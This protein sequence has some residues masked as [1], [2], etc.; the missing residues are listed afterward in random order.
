MSSNISSNHPAH[1]AM[2]GLVYHH[3]KLH[4]QIDE[5]HREVVQDTY[6]KLKSA[7]IEKK[8]VENIEEIMGK[9]VNHL[10]DGVRGLKQEDIQNLQSSIQ[11]SI[12]TFLEENK[13]NGNSEASLQQASH[14]IQQ[15]IQKMSPVEHTGKL[16]STMGKIAMVAGI[17]G[18]SIGM[19]K[20]GNAPSSVV[21]TNTNT[22]TATSPRM[23]NRE[24][25][26]SLESDTSKTKE[27]I[28]PTKTL[29]KQIAEQ[30]YKVETLSE[31]EQQLLTKIL[32]NH[33]K[34][35]ENA[36]GDISKL[37]KMDDNDLVEAAIAGYRI[38]KQ[39]PFEIS[40]EEAID[41]YNLNPAQ[42]DIFKLLVQH[43]PMNQSRRK[44]TLREIK[45]IPLAL[46][47]KTLNFLKITPLEDL[48]NGQIQV[49]NSDFSD[50][51]KKVDKKKKEM[52]GNPSDAQLK[53]LSDAQKIAGYDARNDAESNA[54]SYLAQVNENNKVS[55][56][57]RKAIGTKVII[58]E[59]ITQ[60]PDLKTVEILSPIDMKLNNY[61]FVDN[62]YKIPDET[63]AEWKKS[64]EKSIN[65]I[66]IEN[67]TKIELS[68]TGS[69]SPVPNGFS[70]DGN[71]YSHADLAE[72]R[73]KEGAKNFINLLP[74]E[75]QKKVIVNYTI[76]PTEDPFNGTVKWKDIPKQDR[77]GV[78]RQ[79]RRVTL[80]VKMNGSKI[81]EKNTPQDAEVNKTII[82]SEVFLY[83][84]QKTE[85][86]KEKEA[87]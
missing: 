47:E 4:E 65:T 9:F 67:I 19:A 42:V 82:A 45:E 72:L 8:E 53:A 29:P 25:M 17:V 74:P 79:S 2:Q 69:C 64:I 41:M 58:E 33:K 13:I 86:E 31:R 37:T 77:P 35:P 44:M 16:Q 48:K 32:E 71:Q 11:Q 18:A 63:I 51:H 62:D 1:K 20:A 55:G 27:K 68:S 3:E 10:Y 50:I 66:G 12:R 46:Q 54:N 81:I 38:A 14:D 28:T 40:L 87:N 70:P 83:T 76:I 34:S 22:E 85:K 23:E 15:L 26:V 75:L 52:G 84:P 24:N 73:A 30:Q 57:N 78:Y 49:T 43:D 39:L 61:N 36:T 59:H 5:K 21:S 6:N 7:L 56:Q 60:K 80:D